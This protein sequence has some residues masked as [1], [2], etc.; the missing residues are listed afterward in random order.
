MLLKHILVP[1][2]FSQNSSRAIQYACDLA[3]QSRATLHLLYV[4]KDEGNLGDREKQLERIGS[5][6]DAKSEL[7][8]DTNKQVIHGN[9]PHQIAHYAR[10][11]KIDLIVMGSHGRT[12]LVHMALGSVAES[13]LR[14]APCPVTVLGPHDGEAAT[15]QH[16]F[17]VIQELVGD[18]LEIDAEQG[19]AEMANAVMKNLRVASTT[20]ILMVDELEVQ[21]WIAWK[22]GKWVAVEGQEFIEDTLPIFFETESDTQAVDLIKRAQKLRATDIH[23]D[24]RSDSE[25]TVR[26]R[27]D[28]RLEEYCRLDH[29]V[30]EHLFVQLKTLARLDITDPF[31]PQEGRLRLPASLSKVEVRFSSVPVA[32]GQAVALRILDPQQVLR[33]L[34][35]L[36]LSNTALEET[37]RLLRHREGL[38]LVT[39]PT[40]S[41]KTTSVYS[42]LETI[43]GT[44]TNI[45]SIED[46]VEF[47]A[48]FARQI[49]VDARHGLTMTNGLRAMLRMD[50]DVLF[51]GEIRDLETAEIAMR[52]A[53]SGKHVFST[54]HT[55]SVASTVNAMIDLGLGRPSIAANLTGVINQRLVRRL[56]KNCKEPVKVTEEAA[57]HF[58]S[59]SLPAPETLFV[60]KGCVAC[61]HRGTF[62]RIGV[63][64]VANVND[65]FRDAVLN[66]ENADELAQRL[67]ESEMMTLQQDAFSKA[68][69]GQVSLADAI[70]VR[71]LS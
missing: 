53:A 34:N 18:G 33:P 38:F 2:D 58:N 63:F 3:K 5:S 50:P 9:P 26:L 64:E 6:I 67:R 57:H 47:S 15:I 66:S 29:T 4:S 16:A 20:A 52:A 61:G 21:Q 25:Y 46:P 27:I 65:A 19:R 71:W 1:T 45:V 42:M 51:V 24:P 59:N 70:G 8:L 35:E 37:Q 48:P 11:N 40:G 36:G 22:D 14:E 28:G 44:D 13:V 7:E 62:G 17:S 60:G 32:G 31:H 39:G 55:R 12:G 68:A 30:A 54:L 43:G 49:S 69:A 10:D 23:V 56:C 41:G